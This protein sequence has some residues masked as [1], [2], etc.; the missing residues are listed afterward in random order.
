MRDRLIGSVLHAGAV[1][2]LFSTEQQEWGTTEIADALALSKSSVHALVASLAEIGLLERTPDRRFRLGHK[3]L[4]FGGTVLAGS[5]V[6]N[7]MRD[8]L[9]ELMQRLGRTV[10]LAVRNGQH[11][12]YINRLQGSSSV[13]ASLASAGS[14]L[15]M[16]ASAAGKILL[17]HASEPQTRRIVADLRLEQLTRKTITS[18][19]ALLTELKAVRH[20]GYALSQC[21]Y[22]SSLYCVAAPIHSHDNEVIAAIGI[23]ATAADFDMNKGKLVRDVMHAAQ[24]A[25]REQGWRPSRPPELTGGWAR[26]C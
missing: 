19:G 15:P 25:S 26:S 2:D 20:Q 23:G 11:V 16:H 21:E 5:E 8:M 22:V 12:V 3:L 7:A 24:R 13:P 10:Y 6:F 18:E 17:A 1:L 4:G 14:T 9:T